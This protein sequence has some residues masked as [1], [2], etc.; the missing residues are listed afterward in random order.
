MNWNFPS[1]AF[2]ELK[3]VF[4][5]SKVVMKNQELFTHLDLKKTTECTGTSSG[6]SAS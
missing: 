1:P 5:I 3:K 6:F 2:Q 4:K